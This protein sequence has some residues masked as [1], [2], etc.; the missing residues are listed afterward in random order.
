MEREGKVIVRDIFIVIIRFK[1]FEG[2]LSFYT[3]VRIVIEEF[4]VINF[5]LFKKF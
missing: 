3:V 2:F 5:F 4:K 1:L